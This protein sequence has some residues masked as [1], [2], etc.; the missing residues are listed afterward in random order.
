MAATGHAEI[1]SVAAQSS[2]VYM[3]S[4]H[5]TL[6]NNNQHGVVQAQIMGHCGRKKYPRERHSKY[7]RKTQTVSLHQHDDR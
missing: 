2:V 4:M 7:S 3:M 5:E 1:G 6:T